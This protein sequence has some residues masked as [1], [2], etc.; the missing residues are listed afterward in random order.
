M[1]FFNLPV[2][3]TVNRKKQKSRVSVKLMTKNSISGYFVKV[4]IRNLI[5][6]PRPPA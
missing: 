2:D 5:C 3:G 1:I 6:F 4:C